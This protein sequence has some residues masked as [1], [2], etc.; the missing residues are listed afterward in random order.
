M[1]W[2]SI[3]PVSIS[4]TDLAEKPLKKAP[5]PLQIPGY[6]ILS[7]RAEIPLQFLPEPNGKAICRGAGR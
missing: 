6:G 2:G 1:N 3:K 5:A 4:L 7:L